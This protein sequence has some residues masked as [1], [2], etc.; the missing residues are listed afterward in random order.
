[1]K[2]V[3]IFDFDG[4]LANSLEVGLELANELAPRFG[5]QAIDDINIIRDHSAVHYIFQHIKWYKLPSWAYLMKRNVSKRMNE[6][7]LYDGIAD[8][9]HDLKKD[10]ILGLVGGGKAD[11]HRHILTRFNCDIF[12]FKYANNGTKKHRII[13]KLKKKYTGQKIIMIGDD[14]H[15]IKAAQKSGI[16]SIAV[17]WGTTSKKRLKEFNPDFMV[18]TISELKDSIAKLK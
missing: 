3:L 7:E 17:T 10:F 1:M 13:K 4:T 15:D 6:I 11:Y 16:F 2:T 8:L 12:D 14:S 9:L 18:S 5:Y